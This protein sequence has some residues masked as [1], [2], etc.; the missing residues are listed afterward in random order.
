MT[1]ASF[2]GALEHSGS[3]FELLD[4][5]LD[6]GCVDAL[7]RGVPTEF[8]RGSD[9]RDDEFIV[10]PCLTAPIDGQRHT[11]IPILK[12]L[13]LL[14]AAEGRQEE[15]I[16]ATL[17]A[18][19]FKARR[20]GGWSQIM[21]RALPPD[22]TIPAALAHC[23]AHARALLS[24]PGERAKLEAEWLQALA[25]WCELLQ[26]TR[27]A[28]VRKRPTP[29]TPTKSYS[30]GD[31]DPWPT[32]LYVD[33][34]RGLDG[35][36]L[37]SDDRSEIEPLPT[38][39]SPEAPPSR[40]RAPPAVED[41]PE[42]VEGGEARR[43]RTGFRSALENQFLPWTNRQLNPPDAATL[44][45]AMRA[46]LT[47]GHEARD[48]VGVLAWAHVT[49]Q[50]IEQSLEVGRA[51][52]V[53][54]SYLKGRTYMRY[55]APQEGA[56]EPTPEQATLMRP[57]ATH[58]ALALPDDVADWLDEKLPSGSAGPLRE[59]LSITPHAA[60]AAARD[61]L[62]E[63]RRSGGGQQTLGRVQW[64]LPTALYQV[65][66]DHVPPHL[67]CAINDGLPCPSA[68]YRSYEINQLSQLHRATLTRAGWS[69]PPNP[70]S[71]AEQDTG[72]VGSRLNPGLEHVKLRWCRVTRHF[73]TLVGDETLPLFERHNARELHETLSQM[74]QTFHRAVSDPMESL[75]H[76]DI[77]GRRMLVDDKSQGDA[78]AHRL[79]PLTT[80]AAR[81]C[82]EQID[83]V[84]RLS[85]V[86][87]PEAPKS[88][89]R[90]LA[91]VEHPE[92]RAAPFR[93]LLNERLEVVRLTPKALLEALKGLWDLPINLARH[94]GSTWLLGYTGPD[95]KVT[96]DDA[97]CSLLG[98][99]DLGTQN[100]SLLS[101]VDFETLFATLTPG[102]EELVSEL[103]L[104]SIP[105][106]LPPI[107]AAA[108][109][110]RSRKRPAPMAFGHER[111]EQARARQRANLQTEAEQRIRDRLGAKT[112]EKLSQ[113]DVDALFEEVRKATPNRRNYWASERFEAMRA[114]I[115]AIM[116][117]FEDMKL[118]L[119]AIALA[120]KDAA[121]ICSM[122]GLAA[123]K[124]LQDLRA[125]LAAAS[126]ESFRAW[127]SNK[128]CTD[129]MPVPLV[130]LSLVVDSLVIDPAAW[131]AW[132]AG[133]RALDVFVD[134]D[135]R[136]WIRMPLPT[137]N[138][139]LYPLRRDL[140]EQL[141]GIPAQ[142]W[143]GFEFEVVA[144]LARSLMAP[145]YGLR[146]TLDFWQ[147]L[148]RVRSAS[149]ARMSGIA[150]GYADGSLGSTSPERMCLERRAGM[151]PT[152]EAV[153]AWEATRPFAADTSSALSA[154]GITSAKG[155]G[156]LTQVA[157]FR[158]RMSQVLQKMDRT[159]A[160]T[161][162]KKRPEKLRNG[163]SSA[164]AAACVRISDSTAAAAAT[165]TPPST[166]AG[167][168]KKKA[169]PGRGPGPLTRLLDAIDGQWSDLVESPGLAPSCG[170]A[171]SWVHRMAK[172]GQAGGTDY[173]PKT[174]RN[175]WYSWALRF[176]E[177]FGPVN[178]RH[179]SPAE[180][181]EIYLQIVED[182]EVNNRQHL[183]APMRNFHRYLVLH[184]GVSEIEWSQLRAATG[185]GLSYVDANVIHEH[186]YLKALELLRQD[187]A[188]SDRVQVMQ[189]AV[190]VLLYRFGLR[191]A[192]CLGL[193]SRD[194]VFDA[195]AKRWIVR[196]RG[197]QYRS[198]KTFSARRT[199]VGLETLTE[200]EAK[201]LKAWSAHVETFST[202]TDIRPLF[203]AAATGTQ[204]A[205]L[206]PRRV[207][208][209]RVGQALRAASGDPSIRV[210]HCRH[211]YS[212]RILL[213]GLGHLARGASDA[214]QRKAQD[215][216]MC[217]LR[218][219]LTGETQATRRLIW[220]MAVQLGHGSPL[221][222]FETYCHGGHLIL[223]Q[224]CSDMLW[225]P[226]ADVDEAEWMAW[227]VGTTLRTMQRDFQRKTLQRSDE[228][229]ARV[230][231]QWS[232]VPRLGQ[233]PRVAL[234]ASLPALRLVEGQ[235]SLVTADLIV[236]H[237]RRF[238]RIDGLAERL[239]V[240]ELW[241]E[242]VLLAARDFAARHR[243]Q[244]TPEDQWWI[245]PA[246]VE[247][248][249][250]E[251]NAA[252]SALEA[253]QALG[254]TDLAMHCNAVA[255][256]FVPST[257]MVVVEAEHTLTSV[258]TL[259]KALVDDPQVVQLLVPAK[260]PRRLTPAERER[261]DSLARRKADLM[262][263][264]F[265]PEKPRLAH[266]QGIAFEGSEQLIDYAT[267]L[268]LSVAVH[269]R[270]AGAREGPHD[271]RRAGARV[272]VR[273]RENGHDRVRSAKVFARVLTSAIVS[274]NAETLARDK[275]AQTPA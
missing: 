182:A 155:N 237:A 263:T 26:Q 147:L 114:A 10:A 78:R 81:Q 195:E 174:L 49:G 255:P 76:L 107:V 273:I 23:R 91:M 212:T 5:W 59:T 213:A 54:A 103:G 90:L 16:V 21:P 168:A 48:A 253:L 73:E 58:V 60:V 153:A 166:E 189:A 271:W 69:L 12:A 27:R 170:F 37:P 18:G 207:V 95:G 210:H 122:D 34:D 165:A 118:E 151:P 175:Y 115:V 242:S 116:E 104:R 208:A 53:D 119:P 198:L 149:A 200:A 201:V 11:G 179:V 57:S 62:T 262:K 162:P 108:P 41:D 96:S 171:A 70:D 202:G 97:L 187:T 40:P 216:L 154:A 8:A 24:A 204:G 109:V 238:G 120:V 98:H 156:T 217:R 3:A 176:I 192:E 106:F 92:W 42:T 33:I 46:A 173:A 172:H 80:L 61:W 123:A 2:R 191:I 219:V 30:G 234:T 141:A 63:L 139:R 17:S 35:P 39:E 43:A 88:A 258:A 246:D 244:F 203:A 105:S 9:A 232:R 93:F 82:D 50:L 254:P 77:A 267:V 224:W 125:A 270:T 20:S 239:F 218:D 220:A 112:A 206:F 75:E 64:W 272:A 164:T 25:R 249:E 52:L 177:E 259:A 243:T 194:V 47:P 15:Q 223:R 167:E 55:V 261:R 157:A 28:P 102:L 250:H 99:H 133:S 260:L 227:S 222:T 265:R 275:S 137:R 241:V 159:P 215:V 130:V 163:R 66:S 190:L 256:Y 19:V 148:D 225:T 100:L 85:L 231:G 229:L 56:W 74:F 31:D 236:D 240:S 197:N 110:R 193:Q 13:L 140:A 68:Y 161:R 152:V 72:W 86:I 45:S 181:E 209:L 101:P 121:H 71:A 117:R 144:E 127:R 32:L 185:Q 247:Y 269:G 160:T 145:H 257:R 128:S 87:A 251:T 132:R 199:V 184:H 22:A 83:H 124:W 89:E 264:P 188:V 274:C 268:G 226:T 230:L 4:G 126:M 235:N 36:A 136:P 180:C 67:L 29:A 169:G 211:S 178:P 131:S 65:R 135:E 228:R 146:D 248:P 142:A 1:A 143:H 129:A 183:Y 252:E 196:V 84:R 134:E 7:R 6:Y 245:E 205:E 138:S 266:E 38:S 113:E 186:E 221:T 233:G 44:A 79:I 150:L 158:R 14:G 214:A 111:R 51:P 94:F